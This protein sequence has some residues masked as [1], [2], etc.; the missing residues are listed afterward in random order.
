MNNKDLNI[1]IEHQTT[2]VAET[3]T[4]RILDVKNLK[5][6]FK[7]KNK[8]INIIRGVNLVV[9]KAQI[10]GLVGESGA[11]KSVM[12]QALLNVNPSAITTADHAFLDG[13]DIKALKNFT[14]IRGSKIGYIPQDPTASLNPTRKIW[15]QIDDVLIKHRPEFETK[16]QRI[17]YMIQ[18]L[19]DFGIRDAK[20]RIFQ[21]PH[22]YSGGM[23]QRIVI[24]MTVAARPSLIIADEPTTALDPTVQASVLHLL[25]DI[26][27]KYGISIIFISHNIAVVAKFVDYIYV[28]Y[29]GKIVEKGTKE[30]IFTDPRHPYTWALI[31]SIPEVGNGEKLLTIKGTPPSLAHLPIGDPFAPRNEYA[32]ELDFR[33]EPPLIPVTSSHFAATWLLH[34]DSPKVALPAEVK[35]RVDLFAKAFNIKKGKNEKN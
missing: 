11:G 29:A 12:T 35:K 6:F 13:I 31:S 9:E 15:K 32:L 26:R 25:D 22:T 14:S 24:A 21:Y 34:P 18:L 10:V 17:E 1:N 16:E 19:E 23:K 27:Q 3:N 2:N 5:V 20:N 8:I 33:K 28:M 4:N 7:K 30:E